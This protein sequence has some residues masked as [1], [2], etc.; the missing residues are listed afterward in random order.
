MQLGSPFFGLYEALLKS[1]FG[2]PRVY[3]VEFHPDAVKQLKKLGP[4]FQKRA[5]KIAGQVHGSPAT[6]HN[7]HLRPLAPHEMASAGFGTGAKAGYL[8]K[9]Y[10]TRMI[11]FR[12]GDRI[13]VV[14]VGTRE[15]NVHG[16][17]VR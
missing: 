1:E 13:N 17:S 12:E 9:D 3:Q 14:Y 7:P 10:R 6:E 8:M 4:E 16:R 2:R 11:G 15:D 5:Q